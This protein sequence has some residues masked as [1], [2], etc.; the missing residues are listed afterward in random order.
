[1]KPKAVNLYTD[2]I[3]NLSEL[4]N[5]EAGEVLFALLHYA[6]TWHDGSGEVLEISRV[7]HVAFMP[8][9]KQIDVE[10]AHYEATVKAKSEGGKKGAEKRWQNRDKPSQENGID[11]AGDG[12][13]MAKDDTPIQ[14]DNKHKKEL[15]EVFWKAYPRKVSKQ[16]A[17]KA[18]EKIDVDDAL[19]DKMLAAVAAQK[20]SEQW[21]EERYI[22]HASTWLNQERWNDEPPKLKKGHGDYI[23]RE[24]KTNE[25]FGLEYITEADDD[26]TKILA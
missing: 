23:Q 16:A 13:P 3:E 14:N 26:E 10:F 6:N 12:I 9:K 5:E 20:E 11:M 15:F 21:Q 17:L 18:F 25:R 19:L 22:P 8:M 2:Y 1:M 7:A 4:T 24:I